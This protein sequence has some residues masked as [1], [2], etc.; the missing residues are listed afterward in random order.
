MGKPTR[1]ESGRPTKGGLEVRLLSPPPGDDGSGRAET[2]GRRPAG[3]SRRGGSSPPVSAPILADRLRKWIIST[4]A[5][6]A[7]MGGT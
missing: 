1:L 7:L 4:S 2:L 6:A 3:D 5:A